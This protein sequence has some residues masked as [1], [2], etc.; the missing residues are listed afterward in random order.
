MAVEWENEPA[1]DKVAQWSKGPKSAL[2]LWAFVILTSSQLLFKKIT[3]YKVKKR[4]ILL[5]VQIL[6]ETY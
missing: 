1:S 3:F 4:I 6:L 2:L 5:F